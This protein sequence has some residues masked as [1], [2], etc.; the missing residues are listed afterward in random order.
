MLTRWLDDV[1]S[2]P[3]Y[4]IRIDLMEVNEEFWQRERICTIWSHHFDGIA[5]RLRV[6][7]IKRGV[8]SMN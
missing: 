7:F 3:S 1:Q 8:A 5:I 4:G 2:G 6:I